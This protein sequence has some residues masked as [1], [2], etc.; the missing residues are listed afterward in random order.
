V[1]LSFSFSQKRKFA[2]HK[3]ENFHNFF[4]FFSFLLRFMAEGGLNRFL[5]LI[6]ALL[7][8][9]RSRPP[10]VIVFHPPPSFH[11]TRGL[12]ANGSGVVVAVELRPQ[13][14]HLK[15]GCCLSIS[16]NK[17]THKKIT[18][19]I[20]VKGNSCERAADIALK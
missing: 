14:R 1:D 4:S 3:Q 2:T 17:H 20:F 10:P 6:M 15:D 8:C 7:S 13:R 19:Q 12:M 11:G 5:H 16:C 9:S 18:N